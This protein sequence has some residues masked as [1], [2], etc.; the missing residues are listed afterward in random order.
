MTSWYE[1]CNLGM[2]KER[3][4]YSILPGPIRKLVGHNYLGRSIQLLK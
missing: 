4:V 3:L 1:L 2:D